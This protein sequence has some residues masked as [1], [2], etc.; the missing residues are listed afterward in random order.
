MVMSKANYMYLTPTPTL[1][2]HMHKMTTQSQN[3]NTLAGTGP[4]RAGLFARVPAMARFAQSWC[5]GVTFS[6]LVYT[7]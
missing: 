3:K 5:G 7:R 2:K 4:N 1:Q 6:N